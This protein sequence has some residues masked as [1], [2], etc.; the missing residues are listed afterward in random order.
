[1]NIFSEIKAL[2]SFIFSFVF[3]LRLHIFTSINS[4]KMPELKSLKH[5]TRGFLS[6][7]CHECV[8]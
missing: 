3:F 5:D 7:E 8:A 6:T 1:M 2:N 4:I